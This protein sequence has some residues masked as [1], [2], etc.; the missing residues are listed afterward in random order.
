MG[1]YFTSSS[2]RICMRHRDFIRFAAGT[3]VVAI[4]TAPAMAEQNLQCPPM[5]I[6]SPP[7]PFDRIGDLP[8]KPASFETLNIVEGDPGAEAVAAPAA[9]VPD[10]F[11]YRG[12]GT[13]SN[14]D[15]ARPPDAPMVMVCSYRDTRAYLRAA[16][17]ARMTYCEL[18]LIPNRRSGFCR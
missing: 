11:H 4:L 7:A 1:M 12:V 18:T 8:A 6:A 15:I 5:L 16:I 13:V 3:S 9:L 10:V 17:P 14:W 2:R